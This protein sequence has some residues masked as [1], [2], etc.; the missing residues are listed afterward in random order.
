MA[1]RRYEKAGEEE[2]WPLSDSLLQL[3]DFI[4]NLEKRSETNPNFE[5]AEPDQAVET[6]KFISK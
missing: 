5:A 1:A 6:K 2:G 4:S 3:V